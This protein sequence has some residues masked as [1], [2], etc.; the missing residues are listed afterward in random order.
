MKEIVCNVENSGM[1]EFNNP[2]SEFSDL[3]ESVY[4][5]LPSE[6]LSYLIR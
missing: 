4:F 3:V 6:Y 5:S 2:A 1:C